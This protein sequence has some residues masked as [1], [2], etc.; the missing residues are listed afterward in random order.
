MVGVIDTISELDI[1]IVL[2]INEF[3]K[4]VMEGEGK[5]RGMKEES[6]EI[7]GEGGHPK[8]SALSNVSNEQVQLHLNA[9]TLDVLT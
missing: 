1:V 7:R 6:E 9:I 5:G 4:I 2:L 3:D 8:L